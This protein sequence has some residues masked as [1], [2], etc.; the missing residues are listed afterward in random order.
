MLRWKLLLFV[1]LGISSTYAGTEVRF[2]ADELEA[3]RTLLKPGD[4]VIFLD[5]RKGEFRPGPTLRFFGVPVE[6]FDVELGLGG[7]LADMRFNELVARNIRMHFEA[8]RI[9]AEVPFVD[10]ERG[11]RSAIGAIHFKDARAVIWIRPVERANGTIELVQ[12]GCEFHG[13]IRG[14]GLLA[15]GAILRQV[16]N[17]AA[18]AVERK[19]TRLLSKPEV[20]GAVERGLVKYAQFSENG[21]LDRYVAGTLRVTPTGITYEAE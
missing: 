2:N 3:A 7:Q 14:T 15:S 4:S 13:G 10:R 18:N 5:G 1:C 20:A 9:R 11:I 8:G 12:E 21:R 16:K 17:A 6:E 19:L